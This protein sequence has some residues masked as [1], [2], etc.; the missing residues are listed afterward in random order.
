MA[1]WL[2]QVFHVENQ[3]E[4][5]WVIFGFCAQA[6]FTARF[7]VQWIASER[8]RR[9]V[10][11]RAFWYFS[12]LGGVMLLMYAVY[13][14][15]PVFILGQLFGVVIYARNLWLIFQERRRDAA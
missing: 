8:E 6:M 3:I 12:L 11:P 4:L 2:M 10:M 7:L 1:E 14:Q 13:R 9:S 5:W 15:D